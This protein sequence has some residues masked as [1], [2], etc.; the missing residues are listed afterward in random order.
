MFIYLNDMY[1]FQML[2]FH[3][4]ICP[5]VDGLVCPS[6]HSRFLSDTTHLCCLV[7]WTVITLV[8]YGSV[9]KGDKLCDVTG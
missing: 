4:S 9:L 3:Q 8:V 6:V 7:G 2:N 1:M 5:S